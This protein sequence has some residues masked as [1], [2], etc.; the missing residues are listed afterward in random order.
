M[1]SNPLPDGS[2]GN[3]IWHLAFGEES[4]GWNPYWRLM[5]GRINKIGAMINSSMP[6]ENL[7]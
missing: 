5:P 4:A 3:R 7:I 1:D 2:D 6:G